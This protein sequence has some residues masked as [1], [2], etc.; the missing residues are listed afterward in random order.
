[1]IAA[2]SLLCTDGDGS[3]RRWLL[4]AMVCLWGLRL[5][6]YLLWR[7]A[8]R[9]EDPR[10]RAMRRHWGARFWWVSVITSYSIHYTKLYEDPTRAIPPS[11]GISRLTRG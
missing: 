2:I 5:A 4:V 1:M 11:P 8:G 10:Y 6:G 9:G 7:N 3:A